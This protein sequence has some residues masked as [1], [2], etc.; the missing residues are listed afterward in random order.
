VLACH[1]TPD[2]LARQ[3]AWRQW[4]QLSP[5]DRT[6]YLELRTKFASTPKAVPDPYGLSFAG[7]LREIIDFI[8]DEPL[9]YEVRCILAGVAVAGR[10]ILINT[11][12]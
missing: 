12:N 3:T 10:F 8:D 1:H 11:R 4:F 5:S 2:D 6:R 7:E 9:G